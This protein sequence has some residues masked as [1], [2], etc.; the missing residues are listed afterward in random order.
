MHRLIDRSKIY[1]YL[2][3]LSI[4]LSIH[5]INLINYINNFF[6]IQEIILKVDIEENLNQDQL[7]IADLDNSGIVDILDII[8]LV[9]LILDF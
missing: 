9:N 6:K 4:L 8:T 3:L 7:C 1:F 2:V 5:N